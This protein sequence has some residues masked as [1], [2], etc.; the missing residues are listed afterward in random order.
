[1]PGILICVVGTIIGYTSIKNT[2][3][4]NA[5]V[6]SADAIKYLGMHSQFLQNLDIRG[7]RLEIRVRPVCTCINSAWIKI[8]CVRGGN[9]MS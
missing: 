4:V 8:S 2:Y 5:C 7:V 9:M 1:M 3:S 6:G